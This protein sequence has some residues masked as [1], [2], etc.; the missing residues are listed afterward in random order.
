VK[1]LT[2]STLV[3]SVAPHASTP[4]RLERAAPPSPADAAPGPSAQSLGVR[5]VGTVAVLVL[6]DFTAGARLWGWSRLVLQGW[7]LRH[8][9]GLRFAKVLGSGH[10][11]GFGVRPSA[12]RQGLF[13]T[14]D[15]A[16]A[17]QRFVA[18]SPVL[19]AYRAHA[20]EMLVATLQACSSRGSWSGA[21]VQVSV[22]TPPRGPLVSLTRASIRPRHALAFWR[23][24]PSAERALEQVPG[25][26]LAV[27]LGE[28]PL[29]RQCTVSLWD[30]AVALDAYARQGAHQ[31][32]IRAAY[33][34]RYFSESM[35]V[36]FVPVQLQGVWK[37][38]RHGR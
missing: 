10:E 18:G 23:M 36:R 2:T 12:T 11:G 17:A 19:A 26:R 29:L 37:G 31:Q 8:V 30:N 1:P 9:P 7:P 28:A 32:A 21:A 4:Q 38:E 16:A 5:L 14:F 15:D 34:G 22:P 13:L 35:F 25:C 3:P 20:R 24:A 6:V 33:G 27:G